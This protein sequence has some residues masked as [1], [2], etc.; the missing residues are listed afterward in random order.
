MTSVVIVIKLTYVSKLIRTVAMRPIN[1]PHLAKAKGK[2]RTVPSRSV[3][4]ILNVAINVLEFLD[5]AL[6][7]GLK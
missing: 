2:L 1:I 4:I 6:K 7:G 5:G 3:E